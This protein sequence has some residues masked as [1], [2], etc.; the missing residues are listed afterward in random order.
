MVFN[1]R[2]YETLS[3]EQ[4][5][6]FVE[7][8]PKKLMKP[9]KKED[10]QSAWSHDSDTV[11]T[12]EAAACMVCLDC[13]ER[14]KLDFPRLCKVTEKPGWFK[15]TVEDTGAIK[16]TDIVTRSVDVLCRKIDDVREHAQNA[17]RKMEGQMEVG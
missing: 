7:Q 10:R 17:A 15:F 2:V 3:D 12:D 9:Y 16:P 13:L 14:T 5:R 8:C 11:E 6:D 1:K 4:K